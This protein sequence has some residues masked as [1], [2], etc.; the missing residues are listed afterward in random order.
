[1]LDSILF[2]LTISDSWSLYQEA[3]VRE[4]RKFKSQQLDAE[5]LK[6]KLLEEKSRRERAESELSKLPELQ[7]SMDKLE[8]ELS[9]WKSLLNNIPGVSCPDDIILKLSALQKYVKM[10]LADFSLSLE[11]SSNT[12]SNNY[13]C[14]IRS[15]CGELRWL[16]WGRCPGFS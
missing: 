11:S 4:A 16:F 5:L 8:D 14:H 7:I 2:F 15:L 1:M 9:S 10:V 13:A 6:V 3:E 12:V